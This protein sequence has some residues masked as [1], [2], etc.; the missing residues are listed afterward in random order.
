MLL[1][2]TTCI[3]HCLSQV[4]AIQWQ[5]TIG[6]TEIDNVSDIEQTSDG[7]YIL[8]CLSYSGI[9]GDKTE[10]NYDTTFN[11]SDYWIIKTDAA[12]NIEW[13]NTIGGPEDDRLYSI[14]QTADGGYILGGHS[15]SDS[16]GDKTENSQGSADYWLVKTDAAGNIQWQN[17]IG[18]DGTDYLY[19]V[20]QTIDHGYILGGWSSS[21]T[22]GDQAEGSIGNSDY[23]IVKTDSSGN[24]QWQNTI[25]GTGTD[26]LFSVQQT[27][28]TGY[29]LGGYSDSHISGD[30][31]ENTNGLFDCWIVKTN[32]IGDIQWQN[33]F[34]GHDWEWLRC[35][36]QSSD[37]GYIIGADSRSDISGD[38][39]EN[40]NGDVDIWIVKTNAIG[41]IV[42][43]NTIGG[44][45]SD[46]TYSI[47]E[48][49]DGGYI[50]TAESFSD[51]SG[52]KTSNNYD[53]TLLTADIW[54]IKTDAAGTI[55]W[56]KTIGGDYDELCIDI[57]QT[58][59]SGFVIGGGSLSDIS[60]D[61][62]ENC[63]GTN[64]LW[65]IKLYRD[66]IVNSILS[67]SLP[68]EIT[69]FPNPGDH[70]I[71]VKL[72]KAT[73][74]EMEVSIFNLL[75]KTVMQQHEPALKSGMEMNVSSIP[76]GVY[77]LEIKQGDKIYR[78][79]FIKEQV[80]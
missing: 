15:W 66:T 10:N 77:L 29:I 58:T 4:P 80:R 32:S 63:M 79:K 25:G 9:S 13:Q 41:D 46:A 8:G 31:T 2:Q 11:H 17:T 65:I 59:D 7:G 39:T 64:D 69:I 75:G 37:G 47:K 26:Y 51:I 27:T 54:V 21:D 45:K 53:P 74:S 61:K 30:K 18:G 23:W 19:S 56:Q 33:T 67:F 12:G 42:W 6:G 38:K 76:Q 44:S 35:I 40:S 20:E 16:S 50:L 3:H 73:G 70:V 62:T 55:Q 52:D 72:D 49:T 57:E 22:S 28:D 14:Q 1:L 5:N 48:T 60:G 24:I 36:R 71:T 34:G 78:G 68:D 43:Q